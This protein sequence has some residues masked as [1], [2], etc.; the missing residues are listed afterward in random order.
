MAHSRNR[1]ASPATGRFA[2]IPTPGHTPHH[3]SVVAET[4]RGRLIFTGDATYSE[5]NFRAGVIDGVAP[6]DGQ[7]RASLSRLTALAAERQTLILPAH[8][9]TSPLR[10]AAWEAAASSPNLV[11]G[12]VAQISE[13]GA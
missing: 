10:L 8:D 5:E 3:V 2:S 4:E 9:T 1:R 11:A 7:A 12:R 6:D 13:L